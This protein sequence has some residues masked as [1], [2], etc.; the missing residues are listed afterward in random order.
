MANKLRNIFLLKLVFFAMLY[1]NSAGAEIY[2]WIDDNG[3]TH[4]TDKKP[5]HTSSKPVQ[6]KINTYTGVSY[7]MANLQHS[8]N[9]VIYTT[10]SCGYCKQAISY[11]KRK[12][13][14]F[15]EYD[16]EKDMAA[17]KRHQQMGASGVPVIIVGKKRMNG[18]SEQGFEKIYRQF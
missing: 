10:Q 3:K 4:F 5:D 8:A 18:F 7:D 16:I 12:K 17:R 2:K 13:I 6:L 15:T 11:F 1:A 9:V 14:A